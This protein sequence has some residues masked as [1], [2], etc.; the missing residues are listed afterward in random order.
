[1]CCPDVWNFII[2]MSPTSHWVKSKTQPFCRLSDYIKNKLGLFFP[3]ETE[4]A[5]AVHAAVHAN[6]VFL[7]SLCFGFRY[8]DL[9]FS[10]LWISK[11]FFYKAEVENFSFENACPFHDWPLILRIRKNDFI[12]TNIFTHHLANKKW[13]GT[14]ALQKANITEM[15]GMALPKERMFSFC[16]YT[17]VLYLYIFYPYVYI[18]VV[19]T[20]WQSI[21]CA[22]DRICE[23]K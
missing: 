2:K 9:L 12:F 7:E 4:R 21:G 14:F 16:Y 19:Q 17:V 23:I 15:I 3:S 18:R 22:K 13:R 5:K 1:M 11:P 6:V 20:S 8:K 10:S